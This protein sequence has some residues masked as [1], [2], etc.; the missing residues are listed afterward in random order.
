MVANDLQEDTLGQACQQAIASIRQWV[1]WHRDDVRQWEP[2]P[3]DPQWSGPGG[4]GKLIVVPRRRAV[5]LQR[6]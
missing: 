2:A 4:R 6:P 3:F 5:K 1:G